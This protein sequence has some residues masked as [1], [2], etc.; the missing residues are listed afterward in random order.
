MFQTERGLPAGMRG[1]GQGRMNESGPSEESERQCGRLPFPPLP[2]GP[3]L[4]HRR[5][6]VNRLG[7]FFLGL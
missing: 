6:K 5:E 3:F 4:F 7:D 2:H 1:A